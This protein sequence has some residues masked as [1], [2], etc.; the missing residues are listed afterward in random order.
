MIRAHLSRMCWL[1]AAALSLMGTAPGEASP[2]EASPVEPSPVVT[3][4]AI[5]IGGRLL[6]YTAEVGRTPIRDVA[7]GEPVGALFYVA[8]RLPAKPRVR[9]PITFIWNGGPGSPTASMNF[10][11]FGPRRIEGDRLVDNADTWLTDSDLVFMDAMGTGFSRAATLPDQEAFTSEV[12]DV[13]AT[14][15]FVR[16]W[17]LSHNAEQSPVIV[18]GQSFG[19]ARAGS[20]AYNLLRRGFDVRGLA[21]ISSTAGLPKYENQQMIG[22]AMHIGDYA[23]T[24]LYYHKAPP[25]LGNTP[26]EARSSAEK[27]ARETYLPALMRRAALSADERATI[28]AE[29]ARR[30]GLARED[31]DPVS[32]SLTQAYFLGHI[33]PGR[34]PY[35]LDYRHLEPYAKPSVALGV[36]SIRHDLGYPSDLPYLGVE[37]ISDGFAPSGTYPAPVSET[38]MH[39]YVYGATRAQIETVQKDFGKSGRIGLASFGPP[40]PGATEAM[41]LAPK[42]KILVAHGAYD[43]LGGCSIDAERARHFATRYARAVTTRCYLAG[44]AIYRDAP[45]RAAFAADMRV[46]ARSV[47]QP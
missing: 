1:S 25:E 22:D 3:R 10:E 40:L 4:H 16:A 24:A 26:E 12:G 43:P 28:V 27:W 13:A 18:A 46:L 20:T 29:L 38:W 21:L 37:S 33:V 42:L 17:L 44:H 5:T 32:L 11:G 36:R 6:T 2:V 30:I 19:S 45:A 39:S 14:T 47:A 15:E 9:R 35:Y 31:I 8:Y 23:V 34:M 7:T 41:D